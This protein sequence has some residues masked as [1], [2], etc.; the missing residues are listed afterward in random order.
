MFRA[1]K[2]HATGSYHSQQMHGMNLLNAYNKTPL[3]NMSQK[4][5]ENM[6]TPIQTWQVM[7]TVSD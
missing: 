7:L 2:Q 5:T 6:M 4:G 3:L 1:S